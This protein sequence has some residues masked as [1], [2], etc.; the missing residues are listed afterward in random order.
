[1]CMLQWTRSKVCIV[2]D[3]VEDLV[4]EQK[5]VLR[6]NKIGYRKNFRRNAAVWGASILVQP[7]PKPQKK[8]GRSSTINGEILPLQ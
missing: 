3:Y 6:Q 5:L 1:M 8:F 7:K 2:A 4:V